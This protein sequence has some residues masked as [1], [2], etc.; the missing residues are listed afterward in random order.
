[1]APAAQS[2][3]GLLPH[4]VFGELRRHWGWLLAVG[5]LSVV[6]GTIG[7]GMTWMLTLA[8]VLYFGVLLL[9]I[10]AVQFIQSFKC[11]GWRSVV[12]HVLIALLYLVAG[13]VVVGRPL[14]ALLTLTWMCGTVLLRVGG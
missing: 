3:A 9:L 10:G 12:W 1:M 14:L 2:T 5:I 8:S 11:V 6:L 4:P 13:V 7:L